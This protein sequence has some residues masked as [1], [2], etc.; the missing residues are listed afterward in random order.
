MCN[1]FVRNS[2]SILKGTRH[3]QIASVKC[4]NMQI[5]VKIVLLS[6]YLRNR[7]KGTLLL[8]FLYLGIKDPEG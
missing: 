4:D 7:L 5:Y 1:D 2:W 6:S 3:M 8:F